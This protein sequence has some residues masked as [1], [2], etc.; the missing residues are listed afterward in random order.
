[1]R[2]KTFDR[3]VKDLYVIATDASSTY[4][5]WD[6]VYRRAEAEDRDDEIEIIEADTCSECGKLLV[7][8]RRGEEQHKYIADS[9]DEKGSE[10]EGYVNS[11]G[12]MMNYRWLVEEGHDLR[13]SDEEAAAAIASLP[14]CIV[15]MDGDVYLALTGGGM[16]LSWE[17]AEAYIRLGYLPPVALDLPRMA[18]R[19]DS[20]RDRHILAAMNRSYT[21]T[22]NQM[23]RKKESLRDV[24]KY[25]AERR[26]SAA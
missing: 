25:A 23:K 18:G 13:M 3:P 6:A 24:R 2:R 4:T 22:I 10:C 7:L 12:P 15:K 1:M 9:D 11:E 21:V 17:I 20:R 19:G 16:D 8:T 5:D 26:R 14:L